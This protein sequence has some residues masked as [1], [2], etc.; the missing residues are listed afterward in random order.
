MKEYFER[1]DDRY[2]LTDDAPEWVRDMVCRCHDGELPNDWRYEMIYQIVSEPDAGPDE[3]ADV[4]TSDLL[5]WLSDSIGRIAYVDAIS[6]DWGRP[7]LVM[8]QIRLGQIYAID[9]MIQLI[10]EAKP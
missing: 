8:D 9:M 3:L 10:E 2:I 4:Y 1:K 7:D 5:R 6:E